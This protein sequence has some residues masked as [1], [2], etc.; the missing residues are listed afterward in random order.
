MID[1]LA[2]ILESLPAREFARS[3]SPR[4]A[5]LAQSGSIGSYKGAPDTGQPFQ[6]ERRS[7]FYAQLKISKSACAKLS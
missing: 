5:I 6:H 1:C 4:K 2:E 3:L 7:G